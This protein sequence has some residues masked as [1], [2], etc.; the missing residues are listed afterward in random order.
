MSKHKIIMTTE[1]CFEV[2]NILE[3][4]IQRENVDKDLLSA[5]KK[6][7]V[8]IPSIDY[9]KCNFNYKVKDFKPRKEKRW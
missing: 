2:V 7:N 3:N 9:S 5:Y 6:L 4:Y 8:K 1:E